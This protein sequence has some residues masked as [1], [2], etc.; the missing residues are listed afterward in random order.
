MTQMFHT[1]AT[2][3]DIADSFPQA[4]LDKPVLPFIHDTSI[5]RRA[6]LIR[7]M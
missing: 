6:I 3:K 7:F 1:T 2:G 4:S 5:A